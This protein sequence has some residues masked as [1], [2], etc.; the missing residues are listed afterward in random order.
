ML[1]GTSTCVRWKVSI[2]VARMLMR[3]TK[4]SWPL[5]DTQSPALI[6]R[7]TSRKTPEITLL[8][9]F[10]RPKADA[11][12]QR[13]QHDREVGEVDAERADAD[14]DGDDHAD[15]VQPGIDRLAQRHR[16]VDGRQHA[17]AHDAADQAR[18]QDADDEGHDRHADIAERDGDAADLHAADQ[19]AEARGQDGVGVDAPGGRDEDG[20]QRQ[21]DEVDQQH[22][23]VLA[24]QGGVGRQAEAMAHPPARRRVGRGCF[25]EQVADQAMQQQR[26]GD[27]QAGVV[28]GV[29]QL[30]GER[31]VA[32]QREEDRR[33]HRDA[34]QQARDRP[35]GAADHAPSVPSPSG[36]AGMPGAIAQRRQG[37]Q[38]DDGGQHQSADRRHRVGLAAAVRQG[39]VDEVDAERDRH[40]PAQRLRQVLRAVHW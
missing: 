6:G 11:D 35:P 36:W 17:V 15:I 20:E 25:L 9:M 22:H 31:G 1:L 2:S 19:M 27:Q 16:R 18:Q 24:A 32:Q 33:Q 12:R 39:D 38:R 14:Q 7:S 30:R 5:T 23:D 8:A 40:Q 28:D 34:E 26:D 4:P 21:Q 10:C 13:A 3:R 37:E 29:V